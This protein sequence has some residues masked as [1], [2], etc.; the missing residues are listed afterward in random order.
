MNAFLDL[1]LRGHL[2]PVSVDLR[3]VSIC[4]SWNREHVTLKFH[5]RKWKDVLGIEGALPESRA[6]DIVVL[7]FGI[8]IAY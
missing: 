1:L 7:L 4:V 8:N 5:L 6:E 2:G 3:E